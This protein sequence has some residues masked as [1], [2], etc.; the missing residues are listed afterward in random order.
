MGGGE[1]WVQRDR[2]LGC[3][4]RLSKRVTQIGLSELWQQIV[5]F[6]KSGIGF[7][8]RRV[9]RD[10]LHVQARR[11]GKTRGGAQVPEVAPLKV[12]IL[13]IRG[14][15]MVQASRRGLRCRQ[16]RSVIAPIFVGQEDGRGGQKERGNPGCRPNQRLVDDP[17]PT[18]TGR[19]GRLSCHCDGPG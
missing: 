9:F 5:G 16:N 17:L 3:F 12:K 19:E 7:G 18:C 11:F 14:G 6:R 13:G 1:V 8:V 2:V 4:L 15:S 10:C